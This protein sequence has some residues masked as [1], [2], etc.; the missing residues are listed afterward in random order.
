MQDPRW[1]KFLELHPRASVFHTRP[2]LEALCRTYKYRPVV[3]TRAAP[4]QDLHDGLVFCSIKSWLTGRRLVSLPFSDHCEI[5]AQDREGADVLLASLRDLCVKQ[6]CG[7]A[8]TRSLEDQNG[9]EQFQPVETFHLHQVNLVPDIEILFRNL[10]KGSTQRKILRAKRERL[11]CEECQSDALLD[12]FYRLFRYARRRHGVPPQSR[13]WFRNLVRCFGKSLQ[14]RVAYQEKRPIA[15]MIT[16]RHKDTLVYKYGGSDAQFHN[17]G[18]MQLLFW[19]SIEE[20]KASGL[21]C[22]DLG[23]TDPRNLGLVT[24]KERLGATRSELTYSRY[25]PAAYVSGRPPFKGADWKFRLARRV[26]ASTSNRCLSAI[27]TRL[28]RHIG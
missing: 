19:R 6:N 18:G 21:R 10:H 12:D 14:I 24:F 25:C 20:A 2:W 17:L 7:Y 26:F 11:V 4:G 23:R 16:L 15:A 9:R 1:D 27:G 8:E 22:F 5:L 3:H 28:Y 13:A